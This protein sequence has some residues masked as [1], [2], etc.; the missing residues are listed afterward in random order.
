MA[1]G[2]VYAAIHTGVIRPSPPDLLVVVV[3]VVHGG[4][5]AVRDMWRMCRDRWSTCAA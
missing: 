5:T 4:G 1:L 2:H 3:V